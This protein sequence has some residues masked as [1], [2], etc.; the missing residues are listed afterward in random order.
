[1][2]FKKPELNA[3]RRRLASAL[4]IYDLRDIAK[5]RTPKA[6]FDYTDGAA[7]AELS[8][9]RARQAFEDVDDKVKIFIKTGTVEG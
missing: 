1:M 5:H 4:T 3:K 8:L 9:A 2:K 7:E 6:A